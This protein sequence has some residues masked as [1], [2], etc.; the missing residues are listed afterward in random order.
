MNRQPAARPILLYLVTEDWYFLSHRLPMALAAQRA[1]YDVHVATRVRT[2][3]APPI[4][5][6]GF[7][8]HPLILAA[9]QLQS[10][11]TFFHHSAGAAPVPDAVARSRASRRAAARLGRLAGG[12]RAAGRSLNA[13]AGLGYGFHVRHASR[14]VLRASN[15]ALLVRL[16]LAHPSVGGAGAKPGRPRRDRSLGNSAAI[17]C[18]F[19]GR[20]SISNCLIAAV[21]AGGAGDR[22]LSS[23]GCSKTRASAR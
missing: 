7:T 15:I 18:S 5:A 16:L 4:E 12:G 9:R 13:L 19:P 22:R 20:A 17:A 10:A 1:G 3:T 21:R 8:L 6:Y 14:R 23:A 11:A 2:R